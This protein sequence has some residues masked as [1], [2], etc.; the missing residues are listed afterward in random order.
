M[1]VMAKPLD[2]RST[3][4]LYFKADVMCPMP[5]RWLCCGPLIDTRATGANEGRWWTQGQKGRTKPWS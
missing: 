2:S 1:M 3:A 4:G 5:V